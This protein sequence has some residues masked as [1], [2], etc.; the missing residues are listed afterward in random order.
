MVAPLVIYGLWCLGGC[1]VGGAVGGFFGYKKGESMSKEELEKLAE[2]L[3]TQKKKLAMEI[4]ELKA[5]MEKM[6]ETLDG[7]IVELEK[8]LRILKLEGEV[9]KAEQANAHIRESIAKS[10]Q[11][12]S[13]KSTQRTRSFDSWK[14]E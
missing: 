14:K 8:K 7:K 9:L 10:N 4:D 6:K 5:E 11:S 3:D 1:A 2:D 13:R 12:L